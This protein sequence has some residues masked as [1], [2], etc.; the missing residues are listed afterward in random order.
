MNN[1]ANEIQS[2]LET[3]LN[4][5]QS[6]NRDRMFS[7]TNTLDS[8]L[9][10]HYDDKVA[11]KQELEIVRQQLGMLITSDTDTPA[12]GWWIFRSIL[13]PQMRN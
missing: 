4:N 12:L 1:Q 13:T 7:T 9:I 10:R 3:T 2:F 6:L 5:L 11:Y 8:I